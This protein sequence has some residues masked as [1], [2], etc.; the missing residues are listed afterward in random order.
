MSVTRFHYLSAL[1]SGCLLHQA[2]AALS[3]ECPESNLLLHN[4]VVYTADARQ[5]KAEALAIRGD[6]IVFVGSEEEAG[7]WACGAAEARDLKGSFVF[8]GFTDAHQH[9]EGV[10]RRTR[11]LSLFGIP[12]GFSD[13]AGS[14]GS[15][16]TSAASSPV[17]TSTRSRRTNRCSCPV[18]TAYLPW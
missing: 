14:N 15:G 4:T 2:P 1:L 16:P 7:A 12:N 6:R 18:Q 11:T 5:E 9:L 3:R 17:G 10:G 13:A 8:P